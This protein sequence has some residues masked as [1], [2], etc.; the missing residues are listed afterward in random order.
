MSCNAFN[1]YFTLSVILLNLNLA[2]AQL[3]KEAW[4]WQF[5]V[6]ASLDFSSGN[7]VTG[8]SA[9]HANEGCASVSDSNTGQLLFYTDGT[10]AWDK[11]NNQ[12]PNGFGM[13]GGAGTSTQAALI[14]PQPG[15]STIYY[16]ISADQ[17]GY[18]CGGIP[19]NQGV[20]YSVIDM[21]LNS[22]LGDVVLGS[23]NMLL[24][25]PPTTEKLTAVKHCNG[26]DYWIIDHPFNSNSFNAYLLTSSGISSTPVVSSV[27]T[28]QSHLT[29]AGTYIV[30][31]IGYL[32]ASPNGKRLALGVQQ[33]FPILEIYDFNNA[34]GQVTNPITITYP[35]YGAYGIAFSPDN[36]KL[37]AT[38]GG[39]GFL[40][41]YDLSSNIA[42][43]IIA[44]QT[45]ISGGV[46]YPNRIGALQ[47]STNGKI[48]V[49]ITDSLRLAVINNPNNIGST[50]NFQLNG[51]TLPTG[52]LCIYGLPNFIDANN[53]LIKSLSITNPLCSFSSYMLNA[54]SGNNYQ[55]LNG[56]T[57]QSISIN[58][59]GNYWVS[60]FNAQGCIEVDTFHVTQTKIPIINIIH[61][62]SQCSNL[63]TPIALNAT[64]S[65]VISYLWDNGSTS[66][67]QTITTIGNYWVNYTF[68]NFCVSKD[69]FTYTINNIP[70]INL[71]S[72]TAFCLGNLPLNAFNNSSNYLWNTGE[73]TSSIIATTAETYW[74]KVTNQYG[75]INFDTLIVSPETSLFNFIMPNIVTPNNDGINDFIDFGKHQFSSLQLEIYN[76]WGTK[77]FEN[78]NPSCIWKPTEEDGTYYYI[79]QYIINC[80][81]S[82]QN[83]TLKGFISL[84][85]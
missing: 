53:P 49:S 3:G 68:N 60:Y 5:G 29:S 55:W 25:T 79:L 21:S 9:M 38:I 42:D 56:D 81:N 45:I 75:C 43:T 58:T 61:D 23:K 2:H 50:C 84:I 19:V 4:H 76:R 57:T 6:N 26:T 31:G 73:T 85:K 24:T 15:S 37:Y 16:L 28:I 78:T 54:A 74:V 67:T 30:E 20:H 32:K 72:D 80:G 10:Y 7:P 46:F 40:Y 34:T 8:T 64:D 33:S 48:Y 36:S 59:F 71:G 14:I 18:C 83:K 70:S 47:L 63:V 82:T 65:N 66:P 17:A 52:S 62:T 77:I 41:Q 69:S 1:K 12:M 35:T 51:P 11:N 13:I 22:G 39:T 44:S 27:G